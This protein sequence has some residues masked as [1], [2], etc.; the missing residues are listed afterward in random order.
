MTVTKA[1]K[2][3]A[4]MYEQQVA[5]MPCSVEEMDKRIEALGAKRYGTIVHDCDTKD[6]GAPVA[7]NYHAMLEF[8]N[9]RY[10]TSIAKKLGDKPQTV[11][12]WEDGTA[13]NGFSYLCHR[14]DKARGKF[15][16][17]PTLVN[18][19]FDYPQFLKDAEMQVVKAKGHVN[20]KLLLDDVMNGRISK[21]AAIDQLTGHE[22]ARLKRKLDDVE[23]LCLQRKAK[24]WRGQALADGKHVQVIWLCGLSETGK[25]SLAKEY[26]AKKGDD[27]Y[28]SG[29]TRDA[30]Q[31]YAGQHTVILDELRPESIGYTDLLRIFD[32]FGIDSDVMAPSRY[33]DK[34]L[35]VD[36]FIVTSPYDPKQFYRELL[37]NGNVAKDD[38]F[39]QLK[40]RITLT[41]ELT[42]DYI[43]R[44][45]YETDSEG[46]A[47]VDGE[48]RPNPYSLAG[49]NTSPDDP[50]EL[51]AKLF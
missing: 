33:S 27:V 19:N 10:I 12:K 48:E 1:S 14:T 34:P 17:D 5:H 3:R 6:N 37:R 41:V 43:Y 13:D 22:Y 28:I 8:D 39:F 40:R 11:Q 21:D 29:S 23:A 24:A 9:P 38:G 25:T 47:R 45:E 36:L 35:A 4:M 26:A 30:F 51:Y 46:Y 15:Q 7:D 32:P 18:A 2:Y 44:C 16:Y 50:E 49:R 20:T 42:Q 31:N